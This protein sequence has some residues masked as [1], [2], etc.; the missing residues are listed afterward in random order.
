MSFLCV[1]AHVVVEDGLDV[2]VVL[3][4]HRVEADIRIDE[5]FKL[6]GRDL[7]ESLE[8]GDLAFVFELRDGCLYFRL[9]IAVYRLLLI[10]H[11][12]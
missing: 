10:A 5:P 11:T 4:D 2:F 12:K 1:F 6:L 3:D 8:A 9:I 7:S